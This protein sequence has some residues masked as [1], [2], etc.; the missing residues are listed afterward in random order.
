MGYAPGDGEER[1]RLAFVL[2]N[3]VH[4]I[5]D[6]LSIARSIVLGAAIAHELGHLLISKEH[7]KTGIMKAYLNQSDFRRARQ[8]GLRFTAEQ[9]RLIRNSISAGAAP[10][11]DIADNC[12]Q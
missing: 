6:G 12:A 7:S 5:A 10:S 2:I 3:R 11:E 8:G 9:A 1:G 4:E